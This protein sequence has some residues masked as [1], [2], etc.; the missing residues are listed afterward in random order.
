MRRDMA[1]SGTAF[2]FSFI[3]ICCLFFVGCGDEE[4][5]RETENP[6]LI[7]SLKRAITEEEV[8][9]APM[10]PD[11]GQPFVKEVAYYHDWQFKKPITDSVAPGETVFVKIVFSE[12]MRVEI[13]DDKSARPIL[14]HQINGKRTRFH[15]AG[16]GRIKSGD[17]KVKGNKGDDV[18]IARYKIPEDAEGAFTVAVGRQSQNKDGNTLA[19]FYTHKERLQVNRP[20]P[21][22]EEFVVADTLPPPV[23]SFFI[24]ANQRSVRPNAGP[25]DFVG[26]VYAPTSLLS[27]DTGRAAHPITDVVV[28]ITSGSRSGES[29]STDKGGYYLF[30]N[31]EEDEL[32]LLAEKE[33]FEPK[34]VIVHRSLPT[35]LVNGVS[36]V[37]RGDVQQDPGNIL[38][39]QRWPDEVRFIFEETL[40][41]NDLLYVEGGRPPSG[42]GW[43]GFYNW[44]V[45]VVFGHQHDR[46]DRAGL[47]ET[48]AH[49]IAHAWQ[50]ASVS[51]DGSELKR[52]SAWVNTPEGKS[53]AKAR[54]K[55]WEE[56]GKSKLDTTFGLRGDPD[57]ILLETAAEFCAHYWGVDRWG[58]IPAYGNLRITAPNRYQWAEEWLRK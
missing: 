43:R 26:R 40:V 48:F 14:Y 20:T 44:G 1:T 58:G 38:I 50:H 13:A 42:E 54:R 25:N 47:L 30:P 15:I 16:R 28:T 17:A 33:H 6:V 11:T 52:A 45:I 31:I 29:V 9:M 21:P 53:Y 4:Y 51:V 27:G 37:Y 2:V 32:H 3:S 34:K 8:A 24:P 41:V 57:N 49:E 39:G 19:A 56:V 7:G 35:R 22:S 46:D 18:F 10:K 23:T 55:D 36:L 12:S 5:A